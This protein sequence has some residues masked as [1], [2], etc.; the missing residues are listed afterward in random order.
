MSSSK[1]RL[2]KPCFSSVDLW[3]VSC[4]SFRGQSK[5]KYS[6]SKCMTAFSGRRKNKTIKAMPLRE[7]FHRRTSLQYHNGSLCIQGEYNSFAK[8]SPTKESKISHMQ[9]PS[10]ENVI[11]PVYTL[12]MVEFKAYVVAITKIMRTGKGNYTMSWKSPAEN[13]YISQSRIKLKLFKVESV[14]IASKHGQSHISRAT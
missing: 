14:V 13:F 3:T 2:S 8:N 1:K 4:S 6:A 9:Q 12:Y 5:Q 10:Y 11:K 7:L